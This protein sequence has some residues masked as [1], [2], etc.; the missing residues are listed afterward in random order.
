MGSKRD[1]YEV[2]GVARDVSE[3][4][5]KKAYRTMARQLHPDRN[6]DDPTAED[7]FK[8]AAEAYQVLSDAEKRS[9]YDRFG[10]A[11]LNGS[12]GGGP[13]FQDMGDIFSHF[14]DIFGVDFFGGFGGGGGRRRARPDGPRRGANVR[15][16]VELTLE[17]AVYGVERDL[18]LSHP[19]PCEECNG[20]GAEK[21]QIKTCEDCGGHGQVAHRRGAFVLQSTCP[22]CGGAGSVIATP[23]GVC[24]GQGEVASERQVRVSIP[25]G[26]DEGQ[27][28]RLQGKGQAGRRGGQPGDLMVDVMVRPD[29]NFQ[30]DGLDLVHNLHI[31]F[32]QAALGAMLEVPSLKEGEEP[33]NL[34]V[35]SGVQPGDTLLIRGA[36]V[37]RLDG[38]GRGDVICVVQ[39]DVP[40]E[41]SPKA[42]ELIE[43]LAQTFED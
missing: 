22:T 13:G 1:Y 10:H 34:R 29:E 26:I 21:G 6:P 42:K 28:L 17:E 38:R 4:D 31:S 8:E 14:G 15:T 7:R 19:T 2:L 23:C 30:R 39:V 33:A 12:G 36:G 3:R 27:R 35:P 16:T 18:T 11:G 9:V 25:A 32:P 5:L 24:N 41:L 20:T 37:P 40:K 43:E